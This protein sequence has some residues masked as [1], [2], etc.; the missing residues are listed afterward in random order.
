MWQGDDLWLHGVRF[1]IFTSKIREIRTCKKHNIVFFF[2]FAFETVS[3]SFERKTS[4]QTQSLSMWL[5]YIERWRLQTRNRALSLYNLFFFFF[6]TNIALQPPW[7]FKLAHFSF[8]ILKL[9][10]YMP[11]FLKPQNIDYWRWNFQ[12][13]LFKNLFASFYLLRHTNRN[14]FDNLTILEV[15]VY[16]P[17]DGCRP[18]IQAFCSGKKIQ[19]RSTK[20]TIV[21]AILKICSEEWNKAPPLRMSQAKSI[22]TDIYKVSP[23]Y[24]ILKSIS[25]A[26]PSCSTG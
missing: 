16:K 22:A 14:R 4:L 2:T 24:A 11:P 1:L 12:V 8:W 3:F 10:T 26:E 6:W 17:C 23:V 13:F 9:Y 18:L 19:R 7:S 15:R 20:F 25:G 21:Y 5:H